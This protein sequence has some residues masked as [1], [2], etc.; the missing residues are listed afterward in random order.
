MLA[1]VHHRLL[2]HPYEE[3]RLAMATCFSEI[4]R[5][6][7]PVAPYNDNILKRVLQ[8]IVESLHGL[9]DVKAP[10][11]ALV[12]YVDNHKIIE[13][14]YK[15]ARVENTQRG[16]EGDSYVAN[17]QMVKV[18]L[19]SM[20]SEYLYLL[21]DMDH[22]LKVAEV[23]A[24]KLKEKEDEFREQENRGRIGF[25]KE[26]IKEL[27]RIQQTY[28]LDSFPK[29]SSNKFLD[30]PKLQ[31]EL[32]VKDNIQVVDNSLFEVDVDRTFDNPL[33][34]LDE[35]VL[36]DSSDE[37]GIDCMIWDPIIAPSDEFWP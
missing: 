27:H 5:I 30:Q 4:I 37:N 33:F 22:I 18:A 6:T 29:R 26:V 23:Y 24:N 35:G 14:I 11:C 19:K 28:D 7:T 2:E 9:H 8:L 34:K 17:L 25:F 36:S 1:L 21:L 31:Y 3:F 16:M 15:K 12:C 32:G 10:T 13:N 20:K